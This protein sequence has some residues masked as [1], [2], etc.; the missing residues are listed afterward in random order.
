M[1][2]DN[3]KGRA[4]FVRDVAR[5]QLEG[6]TDGLR[7]AAARLEAFLGGDLTAWTEKHTL[8]LHQASVRIHSHVSVLRPLEEQAHAEEL[9]RLVALG[10]TGAPA[11]HVVRD[12]DQ[13]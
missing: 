2:T 13:R 9:G 6:E 5:A 11:L 12:G 1:S 7:L 8:A 4:D 3:P 10:S